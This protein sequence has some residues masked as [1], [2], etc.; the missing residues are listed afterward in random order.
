MADLAKGP[1]LWLPH[2]LGYGGSLVLSLSLL[3]GLALL[4]LSRS[5]VETVAA[6]RLSIRSSLNAV[7]VHRWPA[8]LSGVLVAAIG[9]F[10]Y[11]RFAPLGVTSQIGTAASGAA[12]LLPDTLYGPGPRP[13]LPAS[14]S[15]PCRPAGR[16]AAD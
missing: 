7:F 9:T 16:S 15:R 10:A 6:D 11:L 2:H 1:V 3:G 5:R 8:V 14:S 4:I 13:S 12:G